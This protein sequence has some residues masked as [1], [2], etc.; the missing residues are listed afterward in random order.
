MPIFARALGCGIITPILEARGRILRETRGRARGL[1][2]GRAGPG[3]AGMDR[4]DSKPAPR[5]SERGGVAVILRRKRTSWSLGLA[6]GLAL[7]W[8]EAGRGRSLQGQDGETHGRARIAVAGT[9]RA[10]RADRADPSAVSS[11]LRRGI[12]PLER[13][14]RRVSTATQ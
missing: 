5:R 9:D 14:Q 13:R 12:A 4:R 10:D 7:G 1:R 11:T 8:R 3:S 6:P 2:A